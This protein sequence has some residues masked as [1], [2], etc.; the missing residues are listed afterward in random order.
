MQVQ[1]MMGKLMSCPNSPQRIISLVPSQT[2]LLYALGLGQRVVGITKF[3][4]HP[5]EWFRS[6]TRIGGTKTLHIDKI[7]ALQPD[8]IIGNKEE[9][10]QAQI[11]A[12][13]GIAPVWMSDIYNV[14][15]ALKMIAH[16]GAL[17]QTE[18]QAH[19]ITAA[20]ERGFAT[21]NNL[22]QGKSV[23]YFIW[24]DPWMV[25]ASDTFIND[26][27]HRL[28]AHNA[29]AQLQR[30]PM[31]D[32]AQ[33]AHTPIDMILL[34]SE[35]YPFKAQHIQE[36]QALQPQAK[37]LLVDGEMFSWYGS[38]LALAPAYF[39]SLQALL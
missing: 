37:I 33:I 11:L 19:T 25:A 34:S 3:C 16:I 38:R 4:I 29:F 13:A 21:P 10:D 8:L 1:D 12:L 28:G 36:L 7:K 35:P 39:Q 31:L 5:D 17:T 26:V 30:Y 22:F 14:T 23:A 6:K 32:D 9:N 27:L 18:T 15:D 2:E 24:R 20:I